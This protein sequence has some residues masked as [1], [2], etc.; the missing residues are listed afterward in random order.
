MFL[1]HIFVIVPLAER[2]LGFHTEV[3]S[4]QCAH[5]LYLGSDLEGNV[6]ASI[7]PILI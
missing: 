1:S 5:E 4:G 2:I 3:S 6:S 7:N